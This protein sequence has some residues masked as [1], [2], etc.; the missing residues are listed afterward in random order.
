MMTKPTVRPVN[1]VAKFAHVANKARVFKDRKAC[2]KRG[3]RKHKG[4]WS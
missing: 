3:Y 2:A 4:D 1:P